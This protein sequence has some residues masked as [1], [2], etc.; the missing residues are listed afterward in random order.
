MTST[1]TEYDAVAP[2]RP[3][4]EQAAWRDVARLSDVVQPVRRTPLLVPDFVP[5]WRP[6]IRFNRIS[7]RL[8]SAF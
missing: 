5:D 8:P 6:T 2:Q 3:N 1:G 4:F 7:G